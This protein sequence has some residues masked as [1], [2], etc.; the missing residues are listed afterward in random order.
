MGAGRPTDYDPKYAD[1]L[2]EY[3]GIEPGSEREVE[4]SKGE[5]QIVYA[6]NN[7]PTLAGFARKIGVHRETLLNWAKLGDDDEPI[8]PEFFDAYKKAKDSQ[9]YILMING[10]RGGYH[11]AFS[12]FTAKNVIGWRD[13]QHLDHTSGDGT[14]SPAKRPKE[15]TLDELREEAKRRGLP[16]SV[17]MEALGDSPKPE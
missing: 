3:F 9:E 5:V 7:L 17:F 6:P 16:E 1:M 12:I 2:N 14:M 10:L 11:P 15:M 13:S 4:N 8:H